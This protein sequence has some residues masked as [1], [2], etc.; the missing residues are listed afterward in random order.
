MFKEKVNTQT[1]TQTHRHRHRHTD[2]DTDTH[3]E[4]QTDTQTHRQT[5]THTHGT[6]DGT[7]TEQW[8]M[9]SA[10]WP[11]ASGAK[12]WK[13]KLKN[14]VHYYNVMTVGFR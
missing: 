12:N 11:M 8:T 2:T 5:H 4:T 10:R 1:Q 6:M 13:I 14:K 3:T 7:L 9:T